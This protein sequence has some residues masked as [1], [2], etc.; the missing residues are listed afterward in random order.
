MNSIIPVGIN[1]HS[2]FSDFYVYEWIIRATGEVFYVGKGRGNRAYEYHYNNESAERIRAANETDIIIVKD[3]LSEE[4]AL[5]LETQEIMRIKTETSWVLTN[6]S[7]PQGVPNAWSPSKTMPAYSFETAPMI[8]TSDVEEHYFGLCARKYDEVALDPLK[9]VYINDRMV[10]P[11]IKDKI[12]GGHYEQYYE[13]TVQLLKQHG[14]R[15]LSSQ[16]V[17]SVSAWVYCG[18]LSLWL[19]ED[20]QKKAVERIG[21]R[22][23]A[24]HIID[25]WKTLK[26]LYG[27]SIQNDTETTEI[28]PINNRVPLSKIPMFED[29]MDALRAGS[30]LLRKGFDYYER[31]SYEGAIEYF[32]KARAKG[33][34]DPSMFHYYAVMFRKLKDYDNEIDIL[35]EAILRYQAYNQDVYGGH[36]LDFKKRRDKAIELMKKSHSKKTN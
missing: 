5:I 36:I 15:I 2:T 7:T 3:S 21:H 34:V 32:D 28:H 33:C 20:D 10:Q 23:T 25:V 31:G 30:T 4:E 12:F 11:E 26:K 13:E 8:Y 29:D 1:T 17:K 35:N 22:V 14:V 9:S 16:Y 6:V 18:N 27:L 19:Y 24:L